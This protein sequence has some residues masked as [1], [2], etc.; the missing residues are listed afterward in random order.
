MPFLLPNLGEN[1][2][3]LLHNEI[4]YLDA[5]K[6]LWLSSPWCY[7]L[8]S[9]FIFPKL[10]DTVT[11]SFSPETVSSLQLLWHMGRLLKQCELL[12]A[13]YRNLLNYTMIPLA[14]VLINW[15]ENQAKA[16]Y[17]FPWMLAQLTV[18]NE[19]V[20]FSNGLIFNTM[21]YAVRLN[22][23]TNIRLVL[24]CILVCRRI[25]FGT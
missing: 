19:C 21:Q 2:V 7:M 11:F 1:T 20:F 13:L 18:S 22:F 15:V 4:Q 25:F 16:F 12:W 5:V 23:V 8:L 14:S 24:V 17:I 10:L 9:I 6:C 3:T